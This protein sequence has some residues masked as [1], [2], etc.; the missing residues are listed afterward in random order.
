LQNRFSNEN[1]QGFT[2][3]EV[4]IA[5]VIL[6][7]VLITMMSYLPTIIK[8]GDQNN[9]K[10]QAVN[11]AVDIEKK[12]LDGTIIPQFN[13]NWSKDVND[14]DEAFQSTVTYLYPDVDGKHHVFQIKV[15]WGSDWRTPR[16]ITTKTILQKTAEVSP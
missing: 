16:E 9:M 13:E 12:L 10:Y 14:G 6:S 7:V 8:W 15:R 4:I 1:Q 3:I 2:I 5:L 11:K